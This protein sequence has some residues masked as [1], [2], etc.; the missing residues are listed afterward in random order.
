MSSRAERTPRTQTVADSHGRW[1]TEGRPASQEVEFSVLPFP[2]QPMLARSVAAIPEQSALTGGAAYE[3]KFDGYRALVFVQAGT[4]RIQSRHG[5]D[6]TGAF[7]DIAAAALENLPSGVVIDG[8][9]VVWGDESGDFTEMHRRLESGARQDQ[10][11]HPASFIAFDV[12][13]GAG[14]DMRRSPFRVRRQA[15][16]IL[17]DDAP[18]PLHVVPQTRDADE[19]RTWMVNYAEAHV[20]VEGVVAKGLGT[21][22]ASGERGWE[23]IRIRDSTEC[24]VGAVIG[25]P[26]A[27]ERLVVGLPDA[28]GVLRPVGLTTELTLPLRRRTGSRLLPADDT[29]P[30][31]ESLTLDALPGWTGDEAGEV[32]LVDPVTVVEVA[33]L[34]DGAG[35]WDAPRDLIRSRPEL[36]AEELDVEPLPV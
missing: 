15:L 2:Q 21:P 13:A 5:R 14:M 31:S 8:E 7:P 20:G 17:L 18:A 27:P 11:H 26:R 1:E 3:P 34:P 10:A 12:L 30:W 9:L 25:S 23:K 22:Y 4:C 35:A 36:R 19:A 32:T 6:I 33:V 29:H 24:V 16:T 28:D